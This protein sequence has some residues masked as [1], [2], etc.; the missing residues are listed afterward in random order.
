[1]HDKEQKQAAISRLITKCRQLGGYKAP[2]S[3]LF[4]VPVKVAWNLSIDLQRAGIIQTNL[5]VFKIHYTKNEG[6]DSGYS[7]RHVAGV[8]ELY[9][10]EPGLRWYPPE[11]FFEGEGAV[12]RSGLYIR[13]AL[14]DLDEA[15]NAVHI[16][17]EPELY[18]I[19]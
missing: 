19:E 12:W 9:W 11:A 14:L 13:S 5:E 2:Q 16:V 15:I 7:Y 10:L 6:N 1:M 18:W 8:E 17:L 4:K 3:M